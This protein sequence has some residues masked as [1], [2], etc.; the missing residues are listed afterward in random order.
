MVDIRL[1]K[2]FRLKSDARQYMLQE[3]RGVKEEE[4][5]W[6]TLSYCATLNSALKD[7]VEKSLRLS[8]ATSVKELIELHKALN[9]KI[10]KL[11]EF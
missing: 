6:V 3:L 7:Y 1:D 10:D 5:S 2:K 11:I 8:S 9:K 4:D